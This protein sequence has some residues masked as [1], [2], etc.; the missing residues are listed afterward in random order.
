MT[1]CDKGKYG[2]GLKVSCLGSEG[3]YKC[4]PNGSMCKPQCEAQTGG[5]C[6]TGAVAELR[7][8]ISAPTT[9]SAS[10]PGS[11]R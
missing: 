5:C 6:C 2:D 10:A 7:P 3:Y 4:C 1:E 9:C 11:S 8:R